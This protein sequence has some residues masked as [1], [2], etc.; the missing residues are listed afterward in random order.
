MLVIN[1][2]ICLSS[3]TY[4]HDKIRVGDQIERFVRRQLIHCVYV[5]KQ[6]VAIQL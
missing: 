2:S 6:S 3:Y 4:I 5:S 1:F